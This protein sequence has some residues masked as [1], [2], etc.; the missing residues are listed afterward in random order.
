MGLL[1]TG[2]PLNWPE[3]KKHA[4]L[5][6]KRGVEQFIKLYRAYKH[7]D[8]D[9]F[10]Y[11]DEVEYSL[12][13]FDHNEKRVYCLLKAQQVLAKIMSTQSVNNK[14][15][16]LWSPEFAN[17]MVEGLPGRPYGDDINC[18]NDIEAN[19]ILRRKKV[20]ELLE[21]NEACMTFSTFPLLGCPNFTWPHSQPTPG[22]GITNSMFFPDSAVFQGHPRYAASLINNRERRQV[23]NGSHIPIFIDKN[24]P[25]P[26][27]D[28]YDRYSICDDQVELFNRRSDHIYLEGIGASCSCLQMTFQAK[29]LNEARRLYDQLTP[30]TPLVLALSASSPIWRGYLS[31]ID[32]RWR[33]ISESLDDRTAEEKGDKPLLGS[34]HSRIHKSRY[35]SVDCYLSEDGA[36]LNDIHIARDEEAYKVSFFLVVYFKVSRQKNLMAPSFLM[37]KS[38]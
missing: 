6:K 16:T 14:N 31:E 33:V 25:Q 7:R 37:L 3:T 12:V 2:E 11:G 26:F 22:R 21:S 32:C 24:T 13:K 15:E 17:F 27:H 28:T 10:K 29:N 34:G 18:I 5:V 19:M 20:Q 30:I 9:S 1:T 36:N 8:L 23:R 4:H 35:D 38:S